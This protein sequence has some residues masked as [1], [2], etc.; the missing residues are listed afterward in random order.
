[1]VDAKVLFDVAC[2][3]VLEC[4]KLKK[5]EIFTKNSISLMK[6]ANGNQVCF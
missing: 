6:M 3:H 5:P 2:N 1:M 4:F